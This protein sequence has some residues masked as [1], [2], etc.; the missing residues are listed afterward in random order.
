MIAEFAVALLVLAVG[1][2]EPYLEW[3]SEPAAALPEATAGRLEG[4][5]LQRVAAQ[6][7]ATAPYGSAI[8]GARGGDGSLWLAASQGVMLRAPGASTWRL[9]HSERWL[10]AGDVTAVT[11]APEGDAYVATAAGVRRLRRVSRT[12][13]DKIALV[14]QN[15]R[16]LHVREGFV[17]EIELAVPG[18]VDAGHS[19]PSNDNDGLWTS[20]YVAAESF[21]Y[22]ATG[23]E[24]ARRRAAESLHALLRL[25]QV[26][27]LP[28]FAARS[29]VPGDEPDPAARYGGQ[30]QRTADGKLWWKGDTSS[31]ELV[32]HYFAYAVYFD[33]AAD[34]SERQA[35]AGVVRRITDHILD[36]GLVYFGPDGKR[37]TWGVWDPPSL[38]H[39]L[40]RIGDRGLNSLEILSFLATAGHITRD[41]RYEAA[42]RELIEQHA[43]AANTVFQKVAWPPEAVNHS[44]DELAFLAYYPLLRYERDAKRREAYLASLRYAWSI[45]RPERSPLFNLI[46]GAGLQSE[47]HADPAKRPQAGLVDAAAYDRDACLAWFRDVPVDTVSWTIR[48]SDRRDVVLGPPDDQGRRRSAT[49]L[50]VG[51]RRVMKWNGDPYVLDGGEEGRV[52]DDGAFILLPYWLGVYHR[53]LD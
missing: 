46:Y 4:E 53:L 39:D 50:P 13:D 45:E 36:N 5:E 12:L 47:R 11:L 34:E 42:A 28:G 35:V 22:A 32:G 24:E 9:F 6:E 27:G 19:Q 26:T 17:G 38:N 15:L 29:I 14:E 16:K 40:R 25:E 7:G 49:P 1:A 23:D 37:T 20:L 30:W 41:A 18:D 33:L 2:S 10:P 31:D 43:Y 48:N 52:R 3:T 44:D 8:G 51:E 21:R